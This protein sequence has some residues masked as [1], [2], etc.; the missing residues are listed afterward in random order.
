M[1][2]PSERIRAAL[3]KTPATRGMEAGQ[4][5]ENKSLLPD[6]AI[7][8]E[9]L[10]ALLSAKPK[11]LPPAQAVEVLLPML[12]ASDE[13]RLKIAEPEQASPAKPVLPQHTDVLVPAH[14]SAVQ[15]ES[16]GEPAKP[17]ETGQTSRAA[18][19]AT[20]SA[21]AVRSAA[22]TVR[23]NTALAVPESPVVDIA[24][25]PSLDSGPTQTE[26]AK[27]NGLAPNPAPVT[28]WTASTPS[29]GSTLFAEAPPPPTEEDVARQE[30]RKQFI[31]WIAPG[32]VLLLLAS[33]T[34]TYLLVS[35]QSNAQKSPASAVP[36]SPSSTPAPVPLQLDVE[37]QTNGQINVRWNP[38]AEKVGKATQGRLVV[39]EE[40]QTARVMQLT[41]DQLG[42][43]HFSY[44][45][46]GERMEFRLEVVDAT[47]AVSQE[48]V[49]AMSP[50]AAAA[51][52]V[53]A[54]R[55]ATGGTET[56][57]ERQAPAQQPVVSSPPVEAP[58]PTRVA[59][60]AFTPPINSNGQEI[61]TVILEPPTI[62]GAGPGGALPVGIATPQSMN[63]IAPV[64][65][66]APAPNGSAQQPIRV[67][68]NI[69]SGL[70]IKRVTPEYPSVAR[71][72]RVQ[73][74]VRFYA[75]V[76]KDGRI[77]DLQTVGG[78]QMLIGPAT[79]AVKQWVYRPT[80]LNGQ[81]V[82]VATQIEVNFSL[83][84]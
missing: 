33:G 1:N 30:S 18:A 55:V 75:I 49:L 29:F 40:N 67:G 58:A 60:R 26:I 25:K 61:R 5:E 82:E 47:G 57:T 80:M 28:E 27:T 4:D 54:S 20:T 44:Q 13:Q 12:G 24:P 17:E 8:D 45:P 39:T 41:R 66:P 6:V 46:S 78:P 36:A 16:P 32:I 65:A 35:R 37:L 68:G 42:I 84:R 9:N 64:A 76:G 21:D 62:G 83:G 10:E 19:T 11:E 22:E 73:G 48:S 71:T 51:T 23:T 50:K 72:A 53:T 63:S 81:P 43:G 14:E 3:R 69:Q 34:T 77:R 2:E 79:A 74:T 15:A 7:S 38:S 52:T 59:A 56:K 70:L 31:R